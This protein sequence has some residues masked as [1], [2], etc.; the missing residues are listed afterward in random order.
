MFQYLK[1]FMPI[2]LMVLLT[3]HQAS[4]QDNHNYATPMGTNV[5]FRDVQDANRTILEMHNLEPFAE[6]IDGLLVAF[7]FRANLSQMKKPV[8]LLTFTTSTEE[9]AH[10]ELYYSNST[11]MLRR[12][13]APGS[14]YY[15]DYELFDPMFVPEEGDVTWEIKVF[16]TGYFFWIETRN[17]R[18]IINN[19]WHAPIFFGIN[20]PDTDFMAQYLNRDAQAKLIFGSSDSSVV[21][22]MPEELSLYTFQYTQLK[23]ELQTNFCDD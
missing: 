23:D 10:L 3:R 16:F 18:R 1:Y 2:A 15:Y 11:I 8:K 6:D 22:T 14:P 12:K 4:A 13:I 17:T 5:F 21:F 7:N 9:N 19:K 20:L